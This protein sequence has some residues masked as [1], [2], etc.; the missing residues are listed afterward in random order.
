MLGK[1][2]LREIGKS[3]KIETSPNR[4][5]GKFHGSGQPEGRNLGEK[6]SIF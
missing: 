2:L 5:G 1:A 6:I 4:S 3:E